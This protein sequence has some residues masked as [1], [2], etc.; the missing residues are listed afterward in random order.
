MEV[1]LGVQGQPVG[2]RVGAERDVPLEGAAHPRRLPPPPPPAAEADALASAGP[3]LGALGDRAVHEHVA[4]QPGADREDRVRPRRRAGRPPRCPPVCQ[5]T[6]RRRA[7]CT[8]GEPG[9]DEAGAAPRTA[10]RVG[11]DAVDVG[12]REPGVG[13]RLEGGVE[14][15]VETGAAEPSA[16]VGLPDA[17]DDRAPLEVGHDAGSKSGK[18]T[19]SCCSNTT[20]TGMPMRTSSIAWCHEVAREAKPLLL[21]EGHQDDGV[22][23][24]AAVPRLVVDGVR[25]QLAAAAHHLG[26]ELGIRRTPGTGAAAGA[27]S[28]RTTGSAGTGAGRP[29]RRSRRSGSSRR[30]R[31]GR[32]RAWAPSRPTG[33]PRCARQ[34]SSP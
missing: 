33:S 1:P 4:G 19:T 32:E 15:E 17:R 11:G 16:D 5:L 26:R 29:H 31:A 10:S 27:G 34:G 30:G 8:S 12:R 2:C 25:V 9:P 6:L 20:C 23:L 22:R 13:D 24:G 3:L 18:H 14:R 28:S 7:S 21:G